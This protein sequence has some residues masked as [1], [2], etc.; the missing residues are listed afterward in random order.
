[1]CNK[2]VV[3]HNGKF[4]VGDVFS[5][6]SLQLVYSDLTLIRTRDAQQIASGY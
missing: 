5:I 1:M 3:T 6:A 2:V 4:H